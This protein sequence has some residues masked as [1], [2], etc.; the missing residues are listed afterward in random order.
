MKLLTLV[1]AVAFSFAAQ[2]NEPVAAPAPTQPAM[3]APADVS[4]PAVKKEHKGHKGNKK[5]HKTK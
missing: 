5:G 1:A 3:S 4:A 2:A